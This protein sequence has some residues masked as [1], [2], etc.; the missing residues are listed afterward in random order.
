MGQPTATKATQSVSCCTPHHRFLKP[1]CYVNTCFQIP[2]SE[3][4]TLAV[5]YFCF[6]FTNA[7]DCHTVVDYPPRLLPSAV[8]AGVKHKSKIKES[9]SNTFNHILTLTRGVIK[10]RVLLF[11][12]RLKN[13]VFL[14]AGRSVTALKHGI[15]ILRFALL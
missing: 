8:N 12:L 7:V 14:K 13:V 6:S 1:L 10:Y 5:N 4:L 9:Y 11:K 2:I 3:P 15:N